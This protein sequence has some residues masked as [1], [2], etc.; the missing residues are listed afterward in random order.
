M[1]NGIIKEKGHI[2]IKYNNSIFVGFE[3]FTVVVLRSIIPEDDTLQ[4]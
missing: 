2:P 1:S 4:F 3:V